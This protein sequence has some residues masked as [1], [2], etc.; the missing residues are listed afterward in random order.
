MNRIV[1][2]ICCRAEEYVLDSQS[3]NF[4]NARHRELLLKI[5]SIFRLPATKF[6]KQNSADRSIVDDDIL[7]AQISVGEYD[8]VFVLS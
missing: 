8:L 2:I 7:E 6:L 5:P 3:N 1:S 4:A